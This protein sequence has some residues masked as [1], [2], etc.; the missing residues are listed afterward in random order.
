MKK[1]LNDLKLKIRELECKRDQFFINTKMIE[2][3]FVND[4]KCKNN[5][6]NIQS[7]TSK[8]KNFNN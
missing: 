3:S 5:Y 6:R 4:D 2:G 8:N 1:N 7:S